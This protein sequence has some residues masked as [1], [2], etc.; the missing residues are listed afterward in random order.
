MVSLAKAIDPL[1]SADPDAGT[2]D[3]EAIGRRIGDADVIGLGE[4]SHG[5]REFSRFKHRLFRYLVTERGVRMLGL[6]ANFAATLAINEY[7]LR[8]TGT[9]ETALTQDCIHRPFGT[10][11][12]LELV[13]WIRDYNEGRPPVE[14]VRVHGVDVQRATVATARLVTFF[15]T[16]DPDVLADE[17]E[18]ID[19]LR[20]T[21]VPDFT[22]E[23]AVRA[24]IS[25]RESVVAT[26]RGAIEANETGYVEATSRTEVDR[27]ARILWMVERGKEQ[28][29]A[30]HERSGA[31]SSFRIRD[32][33][34]AAQVEW[35][36][37]HEPADRMALWAHNAHLTRGAFGGGSF[38]GTRDVPSVGNSLAERT[39]LEYY[40]LGLLLGGGSVRA[41][42]PLD[43]AYRVSDIGSPP[44]GSVPA[45]FARLEEPLFFLDLAGLPEDSPFARWSDTEPI[46][47]VIVGGY[48]DSPVNFIEA[49]V[50]R[51]FDGIVF[52]RD[53]TPTRPLSPDR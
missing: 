38:R 51:Q 6:E 52:I 30:I 34:M 35:L 14:K 16:V 41:T 50:R 19:Q 32:G 5:T 23:D 40:A 21:D 13:E 8:G 53:T 22:D 39:T 1:D 48:G 28:F 33:A 10:E 18:A 2:S 17:R 9:A 3:L 42:D 27:A 7:V 20:E 31:D 49:D 45:L 26:L 12:V 24:N 44:D 15:E 29:E 25:A 4:A 43:G 37:G 46:R 36:L 47:Y 11:S